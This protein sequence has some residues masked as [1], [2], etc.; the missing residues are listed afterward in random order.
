M[1]TSDRLLHTSSI[2]KTGSFDDGG[3]E[4]PIKKL[5]QDV[6]LLLDYK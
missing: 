4:T 5:E 1:S 6:S 3:K 2:M